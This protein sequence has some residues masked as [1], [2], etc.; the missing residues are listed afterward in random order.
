MLTLLLN[1]VYSF[2]C[3]IYSLL[4]AST[5]GAWPSTSSHK[6]YMPA[7]VLSNTC[8]ATLRSATHRA[9]AQPTAKLIKPALYLVLSLLLTPIST[10]QSDNPATETTNAADIS[11]YRYRDLR[12]GQLSDSDSLLSNEEFAQSLRWPGEAGEVVL[13]YLSSPDFNTYL[14]ADSPS[15]VRIAETSNTASEFTGTDAFFVRELE[16]TGNH[17]FTITSSFPQQTGRYHLL[18]QSGLSSLGDHHSSLDENSFLMS[19][20]KPSNA[21]IIAGQAGSAVDVFVSSE[22]LATRFIIYAP[23][24][25]V[26]QSG[27]PRLNPSVRYTFSQDGFYLVFIT[28]AGA[29]GDYRLRLQAVP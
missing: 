13:V 21:Y 18:V 11:V 19:G 16:E 26:A 5:L 20:V 3:S 15:G 24:G 7:A 12:Q 1:S 10:A 6:A 8:A 2:L 17:I 22:A 29:T 4:A 23:D 28:A 27:N 25:S 9:R 14:F